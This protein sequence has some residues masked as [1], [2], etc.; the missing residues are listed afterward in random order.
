MIWPSVS[1][2]KIGSKD[3]KLG[4]NCGIL[5]VY[6]STSVL[7]AFYLQEEQVG[8]FHRNLMRKIGNG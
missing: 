8:L 4:Q 3:K 7:A 1:D 6:L 2:P 5:N